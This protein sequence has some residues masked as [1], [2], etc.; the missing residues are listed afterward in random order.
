MKIA[1][2]GGSFNP[3]HIC[4]VFI[5][6]YVLATTD[7]EQVWWVPCY[8]H[9]FGKELA[10]FHHRFTMCCLA[11]ESMREEFVKVSPIEKERQGTSWTIDTVRYLKDRYPDHAFTWIIGSDVLDELDKWKDFDQLQQL[12]SFIVIP[13]AGSFPEIHDHLQNG[14]F[15][16]F[17]RHARELNGQGRPFFNITQYPTNLERLNEQGYCSDMSRFQLPNISS[18]LIREQIKQYKP[19]YHLVPKKIV[20]YIR[21][22]KLYQE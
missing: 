20:E 11:V 7:V 17:E 3:P 22:H 13:R 21:A 15:P 9:A 6:Y 14:E 1:V 16:G 19:I 12:I 18:T 4:H 5:C 8:R 2:L 10:S